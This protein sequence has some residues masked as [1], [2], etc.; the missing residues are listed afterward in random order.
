MMNK[1]LF[2][3]LFALCLFMGLLRSVYADE[4]ITASLT[5]QEE[6]LTVG[7]VINL[8]L[9]VTHPAEQ[10]V[11]FPQ[12]EQTWGDFEV[13]EQ[14]PTE[15]IT[16]EDGSQS[17]RQTIAVTLW[18][19]GSFTTPLLTVTLSTRSGELSEVMVEPL[20][21]AV[22]SVL[23]AGDT[24][25]REL[26][27][28]ATLSPPSPLPWL[29]GRL[30]L[31]TLIFFAL[32]SSYRRW[33]SKQRAAV[34]DTRAAY[35]IALDDLASIRDQEL[36][37]E[38]GFK[39]HYTLVTEILRRYLEQRYAISAMDQTSSQIKETLE[40]ISI[41]PEH[42]SELMSM[43]GEADLVK[44]ARVEPHIEVAEQFPERAGELILAIRPVEV[45]PEANAEQASAAEVIK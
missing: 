3:I 9:E 5:S 1:K 7:D 43:L 17:S 37:A 15:L 42:K 35:E 6:A 8:V 28:Q 23:E 19:P 22:A 40:G 2:F 30:L 24:D 21:L 12:F 13:G 25:L 14:S 18:A 39:R 10:Y 41:A 4:G 33:R 11:I 26:K 20:T 34:L 44:F 27:P 31:A 45:E 38:G 36:P 29:L 32:W 16:H